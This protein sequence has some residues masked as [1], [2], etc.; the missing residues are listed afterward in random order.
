MI[1]LILILSPDDIHHSNSNKDATTKNN[2]E[3]PVKEV[4]ECMLSSA[5]R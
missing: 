4:R 5:A 1:I 2:D 3:V